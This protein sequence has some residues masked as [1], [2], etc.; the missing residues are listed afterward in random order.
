[1]RMRVLTAGAATAI[2]I[3]ALVACGSSD[4]K[5]EPTSTPTVSATVT[6]AATTTGL[7]NMVDLAKRIAAADAAAGKTLAEG[8]EGFWKPIEDGIKAKDPNTY[9]AIEDAMAGLESGDQT[10]ATQAAGDLETAVTTYL[11]K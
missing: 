4:K 6:T 11:A 9:T 8:L 7:N 1:M 3:P 2:L 10:K 5:A